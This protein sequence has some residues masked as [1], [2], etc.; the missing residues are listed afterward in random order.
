MAMIL[1]APRCVLRILPAAML[2]LS[3]SAA[4]ADPHYVQ[5]DGR[6]V[7]SINKF[8][9]VAGYASYSQEFGF[10]MTRDGTI[11][12]F[13]VAGSIATTPAGINDK[14]FVAG[15]YRSGDTG[16]PY[17]GF[18]RA[19]DGTLTTF[20]V[21]K[22]PGQSTI[23]T[24]IN[25]KGYVTGYFVKSRHHEYGFIR[26]PRGKITKFDCGDAAPRHRSAT[27]SLGINSDLTV[28][29]TCPESGSFLRAADGTFTTLAG[30]GPVALNDAGSV[31]GY[32]GSDYPRSGFLRTPDGTIATFDAS[33]GQGYG[34]QATAINNSNAIV[35]YYADGQSQNHGFL[36]APDGTIT[37]F[38][39]P[40]SSGTF[41]AAIN[42]SGV[43]AGT[44]FASGNVDGFVRI[45]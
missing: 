29:G 19:P 36:R 44:Y 45:P 2:V 8:G 38:D 40:G 17:H 22:I 18:L 28:I 4:L 39:P 13:T 41:P 27:T 14:G 33:G 26:S 35:G 11:T 25:K 23:V 32:D 42:E 5:I 10:V 43:I 12:D 34:T 31:T 1:S 9:T 37:S 20:D 30:L 21:S 7:V 6:R 15:T 16:F 24:G 3:V